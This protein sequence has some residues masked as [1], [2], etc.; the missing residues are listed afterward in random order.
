MEGSIARRRYARHTSRTGVR[1]KYSANER[2]SLGQI[3]LRQ[4]GICAVLLLFIL[5]AKFVDIPA[6]R[7]VTNQVKHVLSQN[8]ELGELISK[9]EKSIGGLGAS[10]D[11][12]SGD[13]ELEQGALST[14]QTSNQTQTS[15]NG[16]TY[17]EDEILDAENMDDDAPASDDAVETTVLSASTV[18]AKK[19][20]IGMISPV[21]GVLSSLYGE[22]T[23]EITG[24]S[25][26]HNGIDISVTGLESV[27]ASLDGKVN[28][29]GVSPAYGK[30]IRI[31][32]A[33][34]LQTV[35]ANCSDIMV[36]KG[37]IVKQSE[38]IAWIGDDYLSV[39]AHLHF[40]VWK[41]GKPVDPLEYIDAVPR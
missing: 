24:V 10:L 35:Y 13:N 17:H 9:A 7:F 2:K 20:D 12:E 29:T 25:K 31:L 23:N 15:S 5:L 27:K 8:I 36:E 14:A 22:I 21:S 18:D 6:A 26:P 37:D 38:E 40:E 11:A 28:E 16:L 41:D 32:H 33:D 3:I 4:G 1:R 19:H 34:G 30:Y 39:G